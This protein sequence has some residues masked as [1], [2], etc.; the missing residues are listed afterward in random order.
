[1]VVF[2]LRK[3]HKNYQQHV[4]RVKFLASDC[5][6][7]KICPLMFSF[8]FSCFYPDNKCHPLSI[9]A[10]NILFISTHLFPFSFFVH[11]T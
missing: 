9:P 3:S 11:F 6:L 8:S 2:F 4:N 5:E 1:M 10:F 7:I